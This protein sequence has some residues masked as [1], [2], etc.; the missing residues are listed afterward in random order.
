MSLEKDQIFFKNFSIVVAILALLMVIFL[1][2]A[3]IIGGTISYGDDSARAEKIS[4][5]TAPV[6][7]VR[8]EGEPAPEE[9]AAADGNGE[10]STAAADSDD[11]A[12]GKST[13]ESVCIACHSGAIDGI[14]ALGD[15]DAWA[16]RIDKGMD[17]LYDN[18]INGYQ[19]E[20]SGMMMPPKGGD[21][22]LSDD[23][24]KAAVDYMVEESQGS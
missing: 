22:S 18:A 4:E 16:P 3:L 8:S 19:G 2:A 15:A 21:D 13:Y 10:S 12:P 5:R 11:A 1:V 23:E 9:M 14:P 6:G 17:K 7:N 20:E 24:V